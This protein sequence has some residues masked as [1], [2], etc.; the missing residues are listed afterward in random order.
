MNKCKID[1]VVLDPLR[2]HFAPLICVYDI[3]CLFIFYVVHYRAISITMLFYTV[4][5][6]T[7]RGYRTTW[8]GPYG[9]LTEQTSCKRTTHMFHKVKFAPENKRKEING[10]ISV[11]MVR[12]CPETQ[13][14][15]DKYNDV[16]QLT[17][18]LLP[19]DAYVRVDRDHWSPLVW[20]LQFC[21]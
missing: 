20:L 21:S 17:T 2:P 13:N 14:F 18:W 3:Y 16:Y 12:I 6:G 1:P 9:T 11:F 7:C 4:T 10:C 5:C 15:L 19:R 8:R